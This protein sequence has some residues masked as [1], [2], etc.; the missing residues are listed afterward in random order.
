MPKS[1]NAVFKANA[2]ANAWTF[3]A[4]TWRRGPAYI[5]GKR[6]MSCRLVKLESL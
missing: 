5:A 2:K 6:T 3:E 4:K 1:V